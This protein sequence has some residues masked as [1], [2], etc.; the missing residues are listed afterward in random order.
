MG[1]RIC[2]MPTILGMRSEHTKANSLP[3]P[4]RGG[5]QWLSAAREGLDR[6]RPAIACLQHT[7]PD[8]DRWGGVGWVGWL[9]GRFPW[10]GR[11]LCAGLLVALTVAQI[12]RL[13]LLA[14][15]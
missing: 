12:A 9:A 10:T 6:P 13:S 8:W 5:V 11:H 3:S 14:S 4:V 1:Q 7:G 15:G 2:T